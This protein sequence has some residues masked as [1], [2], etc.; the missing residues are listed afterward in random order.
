MGTKLHQLVSI[1]VARVARITPVLFLS[2]LCHALP[3]SAAVAETVAESD[4]A[5]T[6]EFFRPCEE[7]LKQLKERGYVVE[8]MIV[9][10][11]DP[12]DSPFGREFDL[13]LAATF[14]ALERADLNRDLH[15]LPWNGAKI[16]EASRDFTTF[17]GMILFKSNAEGSLVPLLL[18]G[19]TPI[20]GVHT[21]AMQEALR[22]AYD[23][24]PRS[25]ADAS[26]QEP[27][28]ETEQPSPIRILGPSFS[29]SAPSINLVLANWRDG[30]FEKWKKERAS[31]ERTKKCKPSSPTE[32]EPSRSVS[33]TI[34]SGSATAVNL[35]PTL[36]HDLALATPDGRFA[37]DADRMSA[38]NLDLMACV[39]NV[40]VPERLGLQTRL[41]GKLNDDLGPNH[42]CFGKP[43]ELP[44]G[45]DAGSVD[46]PGGPDNKRVALLVES[47]AYGRDFED[48][49]FHVVEFPMHVWRLREVYEKHRRTSRGQAGSGEDAEGR[50]SFEL[51][52]RPRG[53][54]TYGEGATLASQEAELRGI[55]QDLARRRFEVVGVVASDVMDMR[56]LVE[57]IHAVAPGSRIVTFEKDLL[58]ARA[59]PGE[60]PRGGVLVASSFPVDWPGE[61]GYESGDSPEKQAASVSRRETSRFSLDAS[62]GVYHAAR[63]LL[64]SASPRPPH[65]VWLSV[66][67]QGDLHTLEKISLERAN[68]DGPGVAESIPSASDAYQEASFFD[69]DGVNSRLPRGWS[70]LLGLFTAG[71]MLA[72]ARAFPHFA[73]LGR[74]RAGATGEAA[75]RPSGG[76]LILGLI[77]VELL[78]RP[79][80]KR[81]DDLAA[82]S[83]RALHALVVL[84][85]LVFGIPYLV[86]GIPAISEFFSR[87][88]DEELT[89]WDAR[90]TLAGNLAPFVV[91][92]LAMLSVTLVV[93]LVGLASRTAYDSWRV[94]QDQ[95]RPSGDRW[96]EAAGAC[97][98]L[99]VTGLLIVAAAVCAQTWIRQGWLNDNSEYFIRR[100]LTPTSGASPLLPVLLLGGTLLGW[101][102]LSLFRHR[103][104]RAIP[105]HDAIA[106]LNLDPK[107]VPQ[108]VRDHVVQ[109]R[110]AVDPAS[111]WQGAG[112]L[113]S[114][115]VVTPALYLALYYGRPMPFLHTLERRGF[116][117]TVS[118]LF[119]LAAIVSVG[120][121]ISLFRG[122][123]SLREILEWLRL[124]DGPS[125]GSET[126]LERVRLA[127]KESESSRDL[128]E[129]RR[130]ETL[131]ALRE[132]LKSSDSPEAAKL[133]A[134]LD[135]A[136]RVARDEP[137]GRWLVVAD[138]RRSTPPALLVAEGSPTPLAKAAREFFAWSMVRF[139][140]DAFLQLLQLMGF[141]TVAL[142][143]ILVAMTIYPFEPQ[144]VLTV[145]VSTLIALGASLSIWV[146][147]QARKERL[148]GALEGNTSSPWQVLAGRLGLYAGLPILSMVANR[149]PELRR[150]AAD[151]LRPLLEAFG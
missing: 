58:L 60:P 138:W 85:P 59:E 150:I 121:G 83:D 15:C 106:R 29:G 9:T 61:G 86:L 18:V 97:I 96:R 28:P 21:Q 129:T 109:L 123:S 75:S 26:G 147:L 81:C 31:A 53:L 70:L 82:S 132:A 33:V 76:N 137:M 43:P 101:I 5:S 102:V 11:P 55:L 87:I 64:S 146:V 88:V 90:S 6:P 24:I 56:F 67:G 115:L 51:T 13:L 63:A 80:W 50:P 124:A 73:P 112:L 54:P 22:I 34:R 10:L 111:L 108:T 84:L 120:A 8:P 79:R 118:V 45:T 110:S 94:L 135:D 14:Q 125:S 52:R 37:V 4:T 144:R 7:R 66:T 32:A 30:L 38:S 142:L 17:P 151:W 68:G 42:K 47:S 116:D 40:F 20:L 35:I 99:L 57:R 1:P 12:L 114:V 25:E 69:L 74:G 2:L 119:V 78:G 105:T 113:W 27:A 49:G 145:Y 107:A 140:R 126:W 95:G 92:M 62:E 104:R 77:P 122:W 98:P 3:G 136:D 128:A 134:R 36:I 127:Y 89:L 131:V 19:E 46:D 149:V 44:E 148:L 23:V 91:L 103:V 133:Q 72:F 130:Q 141:M 93:L 100:S 65:A 139:V 48:S 41:P 71:V 39:W 16:E 117:E 143:L